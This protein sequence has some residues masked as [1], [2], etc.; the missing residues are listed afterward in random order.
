M[1]KGCTTCRNDDSLE[2]NLATEILTPNGQKSEAEYTLASIHRQLIPTKIFKMQ[3]N[4][5]SLVDR[6]FYM[7]IWLFESSIQTYFIIS[8]SKFSRK[9]G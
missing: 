3:G 7:L 5:Q 8:K 9:I 6:W 1:D 2:K 4:N